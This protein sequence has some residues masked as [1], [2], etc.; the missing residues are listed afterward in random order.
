PAELIADANVVTVVPIEVTVFPLIV[1]DSELVK[2]GLV[3]VPLTVGCADDHDASLVADEAEPTC[4][5]VA[6]LVL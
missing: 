4:T 1:T 6:D 3:T 2:V 5:H